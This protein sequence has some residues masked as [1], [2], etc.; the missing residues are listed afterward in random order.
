MHGLGVPPTQ[1][2]AQAMSFDDQRPG[3]AG[4]IW[5]TAP[6]PSPAAPRKAEHDVI[7]ASELG[8]VRALCSCGCGWTS[9]V[10]RAAFPALRDQAWAAAL[11]DADDHCLTAC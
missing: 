6:P 5:N 8:E 4:R 11:R 10:H 2:L 9:A 1:R 7:L 3:T